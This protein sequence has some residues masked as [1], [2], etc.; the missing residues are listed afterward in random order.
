MVG[1]TFAKSHPIHEAIHTVDRSNSQLTAESKVQYTQQDICVK[2]RSNKRPYQQQ[3]RA[4]TDS[5]RTCRETQAPSPQLWP[6][7]PPA[8]G[9]GELFQWL[10]SL[11]G[12]RVNPFGRSTPGDLRSNAGRR[13]AGERVPERERP[14]SIPTSKARTTIRV[15][16]N[17]N[18]KPCVL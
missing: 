6:S 5:K 16:F 17:S 11:R 15:M 9:P 13:G 4:G 2:P 12:F 7:L 18:N 8:L 3:D 1:E 14:I 10:R